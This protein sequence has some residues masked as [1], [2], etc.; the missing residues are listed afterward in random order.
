MPFI[1]ISDDIL[2][3][4]LFFICS[5]VLIGLHFSRDAISLG[6]FG[7]AVRYKCRHISL[8]VYCFLAHSSLQDST[9][10]EL[11]KVNQLYLK[12][13]LKRTDI[14]IKLVRKDSL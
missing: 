2:L 13:T 8:T 9:K 11:G 5:S 10:N 6:G 3:L 1:S 4:L 7:H 14:L 12:R